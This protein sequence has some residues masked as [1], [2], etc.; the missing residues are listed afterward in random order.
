MVDAPI[1]VLALV[2]FKRNSSQVCA[3]S[4]QRVAKCRLCMR[5]EVCK[6]GNEDGPGVS[7]CSEEPSIVWIQVTGEA[8]KVDL[9]P[10]IS[11]I[12]SQEP[13]FLQTPRPPHIIVIFLAGA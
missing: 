1:R 11:L 13:Y 3:C 9:S 10:I 6:G 4:F 12:Y 5:V 8:D 2:P 7:Q